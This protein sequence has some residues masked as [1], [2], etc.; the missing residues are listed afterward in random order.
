MSH[1]A[2]LP[3]RNIRLHD[4]TEEMG[5][6]TEVANLA[7][8]HVSGMAM[9]DVELSTISITNAP[10][11]APPII[12]GTPGDDAIQGNA[13]SDSLEGGGG[14]ILTLADVASADALLGAV[15]VA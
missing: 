4:G 10:Y 2:E 13:G 15:S 6:V 8:T 11:T 14:N 5:E 12:I 9:G 7:F 3:I 1:G